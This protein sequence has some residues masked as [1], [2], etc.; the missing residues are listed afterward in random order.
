MWLPV[1]ALAVALYIDF[2]QTYGKPRDIF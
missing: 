2:R 1:L